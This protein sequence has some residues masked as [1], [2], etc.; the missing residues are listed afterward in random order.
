MINVLEN[1]KK[2]K[3]VIEEEEVEDSEESL[4]DEE[5]FEEVPKSRVKNTR[6]VIA[7]GKSPSESVATNHIT[8]DKVEKKVNS[9]S[10]SKQTEITKLKCANDVL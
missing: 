7:K 9:K 4:S 2:P 5:S 6:K 1:K 3:W 8:P 10:K